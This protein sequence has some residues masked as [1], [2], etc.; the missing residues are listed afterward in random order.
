MEQAEQQDL[1]R[2]RRIQQFVIGQGL[3]QGPRA[4]PGLLGRAARL[5]AGDQLDQRPAG[6]PADALIG[7]H[8]AD[9]QPHPGRDLFGLLEIVFRRQRQALALDRGDALGPFEVRAAVQRHHEHPLPQQRARARAGKALRRRRH[10]GL[11]EPA[12]AAHLAVGAI[13]SDHIANRPVALRLHNQPALEFQAGAHQ[14]GE[15]T[16]LAQ[17]GRNRLGIGMGRQDGVDGLTQP[18]DPAAHRPALDLEGGG[19]IIG[20]RG[21]GVVLRLIG[22]ERSL[23][24]GGGGGASSDRRTSRE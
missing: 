13:V 2:D 10:L 16:G 12:V 15:R 22:H 21:G 17:Q 14:G 18:H 1:R 23:E 4:V 20:G 8:R 7:H 5:I 6:T 3:E 19:Q 24:S 9:R 11:V